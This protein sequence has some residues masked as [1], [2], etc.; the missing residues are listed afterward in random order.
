MKKIRIAVGADGSGSTL[1]AIIDATKPGGLL[2]QKAEVVFI[3]S[4]NTEAYALKRAEQ[5]NI[6]IFVRDKGRY[7]TLSQFFEDIDSRKWMEINLWCLAGMLV[8]IPEWFVKKHDSHIFNSHPAPLYE[9][10]GKGMYGIIPHAVRLEFVRRANKSSTTCATIH[11]VSEEYDKGPV[12]GE[13]WIGIKEDD[14]PETLQKR[15][16]PYEHALYVCTINAWIE[17]EKRLPEIKRDFPLVLP[18]EKDL[19]E[20]IKQEVWKKYLNKH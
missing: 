13:F 19:F 18:A 8:K 4:N 5:E 12:I 2:Y 10:G 3:F 17:N 11:L 1:Q 16:L 20:Q 7:P 14:T 15:L 9:F 6:T